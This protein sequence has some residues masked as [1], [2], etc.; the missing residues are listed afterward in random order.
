MGC[1]CKKKKPVV[2]PQNNVQPTPSQPSQ[3]NQGGGN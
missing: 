3:P 1:G 2:K